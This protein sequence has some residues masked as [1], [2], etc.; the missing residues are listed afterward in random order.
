[1]SLD[2]TLYAVRVLDEDGSGSEADIIAGIEWCLKNDID[3]ASMSLGCGY[4]SRA[5]EAICEKAYEDGLILVA[6]AGMRVMGLIIRQRL[7]EA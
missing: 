5:F 3:V 6:A 1:V 2:S 7:E 4:A